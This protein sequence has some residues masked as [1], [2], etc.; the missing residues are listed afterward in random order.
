MNLGQTLNDTRKE[1][2]QNGIEDASLE[3]EVLVRHVLGIDRATLYAQP[4]HDVSFVEAEHLQKMVI[5]RISGEPSAYITGHREFFGHDFI[6][7]PG[8]LIPRPETELLVEL[9][10]GRYAGAQYTSVADIG[11]G[12]GA[13]AVSLALKIPGIVVYATD[14]SASALNTARENAK[15]HGVADRIIFREG[16]LLEALPEPVD[17]ICAN[18][19][20]VRE[21]DLPE[22]GPLQF[23]PREALAGGPDGLT[24]LERMFRKAP[25]KLKPGG[26]MLLEIGE[27]QATAVTRALD[28]SFPGSLIHLHHD[29]AGTGRVIELRL[30]E[31]RG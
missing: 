15:K 7:S 5:R 26:G 3:A 28:T 14:I 9:A 21:A 24:Y 27:G 10:I 23:E 17:L 31:N 22:D 16:D 6:V 25:G 8:V 29:L 12:S 19:P 30:T 13:I 11:T 18:L 20:Y 2:E 4:E 1:L